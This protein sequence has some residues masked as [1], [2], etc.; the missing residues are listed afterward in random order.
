MYVGVGAFAA[1][2]GAYLLRVAGR[3]SAGVA[4]SVGGACLA[5]VFLAAVYR[6]YPSTRPH[7]RPAPHQGTG[8]GSDDG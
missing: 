5:V 3:H 8:A 1:W 2:V 7:E 6:Y 4:L